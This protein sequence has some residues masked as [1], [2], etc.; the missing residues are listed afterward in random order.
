MLFYQSFSHERH[1]TWHLVLV[2]WTPLRSDSPVACLFRGVT[3]PVQSWTSLYVA[4]LVLF[5]EH[6]F[7]YKVAFW[8]DALN[9][10]IEI[11]SA[12]KI[13]FWVRNWGINSCNPCPR[14]P[15]SSCCRTCDT[16]SLFLPR[17]TERS[18]TLATKSRQAK[19]V[20]P[21]GSN[22]NARKQCFDLPAQILLNTSYQ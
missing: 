4:P 22:L 14:F 21:I 2:C 17:L 19:C 8:Y 3:P 11:K 13:C 15:R 1:C 12:S 9:S 20:K 18:A 6:H 5:A 16:S 7:D 10:K